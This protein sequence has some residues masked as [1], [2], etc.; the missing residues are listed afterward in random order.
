MTQYIPHGFGQIRPAWHARQ[1]ILQPE[2]QA[3]DPRPTSHLTNLQSRGR[4]DGLAVRTGL[5][6]IRSR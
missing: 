4:E 5:L 2:L 6:K 1:A 3:F